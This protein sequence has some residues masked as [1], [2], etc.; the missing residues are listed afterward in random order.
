MEQENIK[1]M[2]KSKN[3]KNIDVVWMIT[4]AA[5]LVTVVRYS[6]AFISSDMGQ[7][8]G[9]L[10]DWV[11]FFMGVTGLGMG[12]LDVFGGAY[13]FNG[14]R[15][16]MPRSGVKWSFKFK[17][18]TFFVFGLISAGMIIL[19]PFTISRITQTSVADVLGKGFG[20]WFWSSMVNI[21]PYFL[22]GGVFAGNKAIAEESSGETS[23]GGESSNEVS[24]KDGNSLESS[25][26]VSSDWRKIRPTLKPKDLEK[27]ANL[28]PDQM[29]AYSSQTGFTYKTIS[30][31]RSN[32]R[33]ELGIGNE[34]DNS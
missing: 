24:K 21:V 3:K 13:L 18:L 8:T 15:K 14:W 9:A 11:T 34:N 25:K 12:I 5:A 23:N 10:S 32:A 4:I 17:T 30:N 27:L 6:A 7:I 20:M 28:N 16:V 33:Q 1:E 22:V 31:W 2:E 29:R 26:K 19:V